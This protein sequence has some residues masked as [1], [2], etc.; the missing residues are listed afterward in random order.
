MHTTLNGPAETYDAKRRHLS[1]DR[2]PRRIARLVL[3]GTV[4]LM[5]VFA[6]TRAAQ[7]QGIPQ[8]K[9]GVVI[10]FGG[11]SVYTACVDLGT[12]G[13]ATGEELLHTAG[14][15]VLIEYS[16]QGGAVCKIGVQGCN[17]PD[18]NCWCQ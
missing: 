11:G 10:D 12:D 18:Q 9:A 5:A 4:L 1:F 2:P 16:S 8:N 15:D 14:F 3:L 7:A 17:F 13:Q 6:H